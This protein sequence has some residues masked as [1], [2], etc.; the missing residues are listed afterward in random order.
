MKN[1]LSNYYSNLVKM[2]LKKLKEERGLSITKMALILGLSDSYLGH[3]LSMKSPKTPSIQLLGCICE[4]AN[5]PITY[6]FEDK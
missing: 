1:N 4:K 2:N 5:V 6:F 3:L